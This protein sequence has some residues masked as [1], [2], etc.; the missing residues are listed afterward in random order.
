MYICSNV[1]FVAEYIL[2][3][4]FQVHSKEKTESKKTEYKGKLHKCQ[5]CSKVFKTNTELWRH[6]QTH[7]TERPFLCK[8]CPGTLKSY[9][10]LDKHYQIHNSERPWK[11]EQCPKTFKIAHSLNNHMESH[12]TEKIH[13]YK[14]ATNPIKFCTVLKSTPGK[15]MIKVYMTYN[16]QL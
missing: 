1:W 15:F 13:V 2:R 16:M 8:H 6:E 3:R 7:S 10:Q 11:C 9:D 14:N 4:T 5:Q 12:L